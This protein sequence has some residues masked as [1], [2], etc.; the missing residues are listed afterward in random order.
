L[1]FENPKGKSMAKKLMTRG[2]LA[3][4]LGVSY[5]TIYQWVKAGRIPEINLGRRT[6]RYDLK[7]VMDALQKGR[8][9]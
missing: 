2:E 1:G 3:S 6:R 8:A 5:L 4:Y 9:K 7:A